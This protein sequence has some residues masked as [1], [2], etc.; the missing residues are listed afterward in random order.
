MIVFSM[1]A[2]IAVGFIWHLKS[3]KTHVPKILSSVVSGYLLFA[4]GLKG[5]MPLKEATSLV[6]ILSGIGFSFFLTGV[7]FAL[8]VKSGFPILRA[9]ITAAFYGSVSAITF[10]AGDLFLRGN[11]LAFEGILSATMAAMEVP[12]IIMGIVLPMIFSGTGAEKPKI[13]LRQIFA[14]ILN[15]SVAM[16][17]FGIGIGMI[18]ILAPAIKMILIPFYAVV[19]V[20]LACAGKKIAAKIKDVRKQG[21]FLKL[22]PAM[23]LIGLIVGMFIGKVLGFSMEGIFMFGLLGASKSYIAVPAAFEEIFPQ[24]HAT[25]AAA[26]SAALAIT[27]PLNLLLFPV[28]LELAKIVFAL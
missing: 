5:G 24:E 14:A 4:I 16:L 19:F 3:P 25:T 10:T 13:S 11:G 2:A 22:N 9:A 21:F 6:P 20:F 17:M 12:P 8:L 18:D 7:A 1:F 27:L 23:I 26:I 15:P 28:Y